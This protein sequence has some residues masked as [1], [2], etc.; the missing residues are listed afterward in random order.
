VTGRPPARKPA[1]RRTAATRAPATKTAAKRT[2]AKR[3][4]AK[5]APAKR[6]PAK[7]APAKR[8]PARRPPARRTRVG[9]TL[10]AVVVA[11]ALL[12]AAWWMQRP[13]PAPPAPEAS[14][15]A[16][17]GYVPPAAPSLPT[18]SGVAA[19]NVPVVDPAWTADV[20]TRTGI[21]ATAV[22]AYAVAELRVRREQPDCA[23][24][25]ST[26]AGIGWVESRHGTIDGSVLGLDGLSTPPIVGPAL[27]G[28]GAFAAIRS[29]PAFAEFHG[30][31]TWDHAVGPLQFIGSTWRRWAGDGDGDGVADPNDVKDAAYAAAR[32]LCHDDPDLTTGQGWADAVFSYNHDDAYVASVYAAAT[33]YAA[34]TS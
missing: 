13:E 33:G 1:A 26:L 6:S 12:T 8:T 27:D 3:A 31:A 19:A 25:W 18:P 4:P 29:D 5:R 32:Y 15:S 10:V 7:R 2:A 17:G 9:P 22:D 23:I 21:P 11:A 14:T 30:D 16:P 34:A 28:T 24:G 20:A